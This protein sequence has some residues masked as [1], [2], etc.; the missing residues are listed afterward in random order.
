MTLASAA[1][2]EA[3]TLDATVEV[4]RTGSVSALPFGDGSGQ[5]AESAAAKTGLAGGKPIAPVPGQA[6]HHHRHSPQADLDTLIALA[7]PASSD[8]DR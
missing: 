1:V 6:G 7:T 8:E 4:W 2:S 3:H 5:L